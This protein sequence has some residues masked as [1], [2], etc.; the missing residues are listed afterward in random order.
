MNELVA[1]CKKNGLMPFANFNRLQLVPPCNISDADAKL[2]L[3]LL[4]SSISEIN[5]YYGV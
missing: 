3:E 1:A 5:K 2:G 4:D